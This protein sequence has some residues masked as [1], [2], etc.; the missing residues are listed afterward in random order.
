MVNKKHLETSRI[1]LTKE[2]LTLFFDRVLAV[3]CG[4]RSVLARSL[5]FSERTVR[6]WQCGRSS[7]PKSA[8]LYML[9][10]TNTAALDWEHKE[11]DQYWY[12]SFAGK[13]GGKARIIKHGNPGTL[14][15]RSKGGAHSVLVQRRRKSPNGFILAKKIRIPKVSK[16][17]AELLGI[18]WGDG[19][20]G[21]FQ[22]SFVTSSVT[23]REHAIFVHKLIRRLFRVEVTW[24]ERTTAHAIEL[25]ISS[26][27]F[28]KQLVKLGMPLGNKLAEGG[29]RLHIPMWIKDNETYAKAFVRG[30]FDTDGCVAIDKH[31]I[32]GKEYAYVT[33][34]ITSASDTLLQDVALLLRS[35]G[36]R[37]TL[38]STQNSVFVRRQAD[39]AK[40]FKTVGSSNP[41]HIGRYRRM[42]GYRSGH[43]GTDSKSVGRRK[44]HVGSNPTPSASSF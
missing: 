34:T 15:G 4:S 11:S 43:T 1:F 23:D 17:L 30:L 10:M 25:I 35:W 26:V 27:T 37:A 29:K 3:H 24:K 7:I 21:V 22:S 2:N 39:V 40:F 44:P 36:I 20:A 32:K 8:F 18:F 28:G 41:K 38:T 33:W 12:A 5:R 9:S 6:E 13:L 31:R 42:E 14:K 19:H 16:N